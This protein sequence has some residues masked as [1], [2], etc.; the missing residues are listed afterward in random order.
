MDLI[1]CYTQERD[2]IIVLLVFWPDAESMTVRAGEGVG[3]E[4]LSVVYSFDGE[5]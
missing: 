1:Y 5:Y 2:N 4:G 3:G